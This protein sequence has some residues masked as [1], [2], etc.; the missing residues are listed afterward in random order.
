MP[1]SHPT[2]EDRTLAPATRLLHTGYDPQSYHG[3]VNPPVVHASTVL[4][5]DAASHVANAQRYTYGRTGTPTID[6]L[7]AALMELEGAAAVRLAPS[8][9][10]AVSLALMACLS[11]GDHL[12]VT[13]SIYA[14]T[15]RFCDTVLKRFGVETS[16]YDPALDADGLAALFRPNTR[17]LM[18]EAPGTATFEM[19]DVPA[20]SAMARARGLVVL[21][22]N[23]WAT[24]LFF[25]PLEH[26]VD[27]SI[28]A[29]TKYISGHS[30]VLIGTVA[31]S[32]R[33]AHDLTATH[34]NLGLH[35]GPDDVYLAWRGLKTMAVRLA[36]HQES[37][38]IVA[39]WLAS[40]PEVT[41]VRHPG[42]AEDP[43]HAL[44]TRDFS[45]ASGLFA[46]D[47]APV[48]DAA[49]RRFLDTLTLFGM[50][51][52]WGG[53]ES[54]VIKARPEEA[55]TAV[56]WRGAGPLMRF[57]IGLEDPGDL[58][59]DLERGFAAM[60]EADEDGGE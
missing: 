6:A 42:L 29:A 14:P 56:P 30:D 26:G 46:A 20:L 22:D 12:L 41:R 19:Q 4:F 45:G 1:P 37:G 5:R 15:R 8:G 33:L 49:L 21:M 51:Y 57:H 39:R 7:E 9:L 25:K 53:F 38:L 36:R 54:L 3:F 16:Y 18:L 48:S 2:D 35:V 43:G 11:A 44:W 28:Q 17:A 55:R 52:S 58:I 32:E 31:A 13:D 50:G 47:F 60:V 23:T 59:A 34:R 27:L 10:A 40:R 24:P